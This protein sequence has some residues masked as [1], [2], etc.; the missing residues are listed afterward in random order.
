MITK[1]ASEIINAACDLA[2]IQNSDFRQWNTSVGYLNDIYRE[3]YNSLAGT[4]DGYY[5]KEFTA[6][7]PTIT[8]PDDCQTINN[9]YRLENANLK[10]ILRCPAGQEGTPGTYDTKNDVIRIFDNGQMN[11][12]RIEY[13]PNP[14]TLTMPRESLTI[15]LDAN[16]IEEIG[17]MTQEYFYFKDGEGNGKKYFFFTREVEDAT[18]VPQ[19]NSKYLGLSFSFDPYNQIILLDGDDVTSAFTKLNIKG[20]NIPIKSIHLNSPWLVVNYEDDTICVMNNLTLVEWNNKVA[21]GHDTKGQAFAINTNDKTGYG[22]IYLDE[23]DEKLYLASFVP[24]TIMNYPNN[25]L[26]A[27]LEAELATLFSGLVGAQNAYVTDQL[28]PARRQA[29][30]EAIRRDEF[31]ATRTRNV[32]ARS[33]FMGGATKS[34]TKSSAKSEAKKAE[35][36]RKATNKAAKAENKA[37]KDAD[38]D[39]KISKEEKASYKSAEK[40]RKAANKEAKATNKKTAQ[41]NYAKEQ[42]AKGQSATRYDGKSRD[43]N[44][45]GK[46]GFF[47]KIGNAASNATQYA[48]GKTEKQQQKKADKIKKYDRDGDGKVNFDERV[49]GIGTDVANGV[50]NFVKDPIGSIA[51]AVDKVIITPSEM[52]RKATELYDDVFGSNTKD[53]KLNTAIQ[54]AAQVADWA[55]NPAAKAADLTADWVKGL[56]TEIETTDTATMTPE[57][58]EKY[59]SD[60]ADRAKEQRQSYTSESSAPK[61]SP[62]TFNPAKIHGYGPNQEMTYAD[63]L[64]WLKQYHKQTQTEEIPATA[65][66]PSEQT[67][68]IGLA[69]SSTAMSD[70]RVKNIVMSPYAQDYMVQSAVKIA[71]AVN[72]QIY[73]NDTMKKVIMLNMMAN[74]IHR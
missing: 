4:S 33:F 58:K 8:I 35:T 37:K 18:F 19:D 7:G 13:T 70:A 17:K 28:L 24:D 27:L 32:A 56:D 21:T 34:S 41:A 74:G 38:G 71:N 59:K 72:S 68:S 12:Y 63:Y 47:E 6:Q 1:T 46:E 62:Q 20:E 55:I 66:P 57:Q 22:L 39:G 50:K 53:S 54:N 14:Q 3:L 26:F 67:Q 23:D 5:V 42:E 45:D 9:I 30:Y 36:E 64:E 51:T 44:G 31:M 69:K 25:S 52:H 15:D 65:T 40:E 2:Q 61:Q 10:A 73:K 48:K 43:R 60:K 11:E 16:N 49:I 29:F